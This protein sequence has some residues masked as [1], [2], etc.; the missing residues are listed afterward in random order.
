MCFELL[1]FARVGGGR[2]THKLGQKTVCLVTS[3]AATA[4]NATS[5]KVVLRRGNVDNARGSLS[6]M[7]KQET[8]GVQG[9]S[10]LAMCQITLARRKPA[11]IV[12]PSPRR[13]P[14][15]FFQSP[16]DKIYVKSDVK[17]ENKLGVLPDRSVWPLTW[18]PVPVATFS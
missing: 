7:G 9:G 8:R 6:E 1:C 5:M 15:A 10:G 16:G 2:G 12:H 17:P 3:E 4:G 18:W 13:I 14:K 11:S